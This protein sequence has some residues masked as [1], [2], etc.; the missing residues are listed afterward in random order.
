MEHHPVVS[1]QEWL[2]A[3]KALLV[4]EKEATRLRD[5]LTAERMALP[6]IK[7]DKEYTFDTPE[8]KKTLA[9]LFAGRSQLVIYHFMFAPGWGAGCPG[10]SHMS[11]HLAGPLP[12]L[13][14]HDV[15]LAVVSRA[16]IAEIEAYKKRMGWHFPWVSS[17]GTDFNYDFHVSLAKDDLA[18]GTAIYNFATLPAQADAADVEA[19]GL[20]VFYKDESGQ[21]FHTYSAYA[22]GV[23]ELVGTLMILDRAPKGRNEKTAGDFVRR[24]DEY[25]KAQAAR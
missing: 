20:S 9:D 19:H 14:H 17:F 15:S 22:R 16:P 23:E 2:V 8:G 18:S 10:C 21:V 6:W 24:H 5:K 11:D 7:I 12:H 4:K 13:E 25:E 1:P 3:R